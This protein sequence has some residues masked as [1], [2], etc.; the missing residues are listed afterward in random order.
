MRVSIII[1]VYNAEKFLAEAVISAIEQPETAEVLLIEDGSSD[2]SLEISKQLSKKFPKVKLLQHPDGSNYGAGASRNLGIRNASFSY[3]AFLDADDFFLP[4]RFETAAQLFANHSWIDGVYEAVGVHFE[5]EKSRERWFSRTGVTITTVKQAISPDEL[6]E[7][8]SPVG[9]SGYCPTGGWVV[10]RAIFDQ[11][12]YF[13]ENLRL[14]QDTA[15]FIKFSAVG[16]MMAGNLATPVAMRRVHA[17]N[18]SS[19]RRSC[20]Q[21]YLSF[22]KMWATILLWSDRYLD[23]DKQAI[24][25]RK[26]LRHALKPYKPTKNLLLKMVLVGLQFIRFVIKF[27]NNIF[28]SRFWE[29]IFQ[30][31]SL[32]KL[33]N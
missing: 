31:E 1:P 5:D 29:E 24:I 14:H 17:E 13:D 4:N 10:K 21:E 23:D 30:F 33:R 19:A 15:M 12:G 11:T 28:Q 25:Y 8:Q 6:F 7:N 26:F 22:Q 27:P 20:W 2:R 3:I 32:A 9:S 16:K 18:R